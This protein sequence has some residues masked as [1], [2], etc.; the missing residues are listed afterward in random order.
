MIRERKHNS[1]ELVQISGNPGESERE[2]KHLTTLSITGS[3][4]KKKNTLSIT[5]NPRELEF[6]TDFNVGISIY[7]MPFPFTPKPIP[8]PGAIVNVNSPNYC[9]RNYKQAEPKE[10]KTNNCTTISKQ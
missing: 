4:K 7:L 1:T 2:K 8:K 5:G 3:S 10:N 9:R 6:N